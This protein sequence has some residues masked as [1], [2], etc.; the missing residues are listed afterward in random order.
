MKTIV[1]ST[2]FVS[3]LIHQ[4][5]AFGD[6]IGITS[7]TGLPK[8]RKLEV[9]QML[10]KMAREYTAT[11]LANRQALY[12]DMNG[13]VGVLTFDAVFSD[14]IETFSTTPTDEGA[15]A[16]AKAARKEGSAYA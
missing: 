3:V 1:P 15:E 8:L 5:D 2:L 10:E 7:A 13:R 14:L 9:D 11:S 16:E 12:Q 4:M 6:Y